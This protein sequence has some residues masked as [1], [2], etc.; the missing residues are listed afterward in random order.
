MINVA[1]K[2]EKVMTTTH[3]EKCY[4]RWDA[5]SECETDKQGIAFAAGAIFAT[6]ICVAAFL[7]A[8]TL[9]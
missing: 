4:Q 5:C 7:L 1:E 9:T 6:I 2:K 8:R 3:C